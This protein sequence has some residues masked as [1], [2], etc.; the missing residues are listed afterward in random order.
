MGFI[1]SN[2]KFISNSNRAEC[3]ITKSF[4]HTILSQFIPKAWPFPKMYL[5]RELHEF[6]HNPIHPFNIQTHKSH[7]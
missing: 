4:L 3:H 2:Q 1:E 7:I 5:K 6:P